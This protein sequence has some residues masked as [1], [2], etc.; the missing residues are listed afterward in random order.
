MTPFAPPPAQQPP[1]QYRHVD[2]A[3]PAELAGPKLV[4]ARLEM[5]VLSD[6]AYSA[7]LL[8]PEQLRLYC[9]RDG[10]SVAEFIRKH[11]TL[12]VTT[13]VN[14]GYFDVEPS[15]LLLPTGLVVSQSTV[16]WPSS[17][18]VARGGDGAR[19]RHAVKAARESAWTAVVYATRDGHAGILP[20][21]EFDQR[22]LSGG[23]YPQI[24][25]ALEAGPLLVCNG[26]PTPGQY[27]LL[28]SSNKQVHRSA[29]GV[30]ADGTIVLFVTKNTM[31]Y[32]QAAQALL[33]IGAV[34]A[35]AL[36]G[37][38]SSAFFAPLHPDANVTSPGSGVVGDKIS[39]ILYAAP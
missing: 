36:D 10:I 27:D 25:T 28:G 24:R 3:G 13:A 4:R 19:A 15:G 29:V 35:M 12:A 31:T 6:T 26:K 5:R 22:F 2:G 20:V 23:C 21:A 30:T 33:K 37:G 14:G 7:R 34:D 11:R 1:A 8:L 38:P 32:G 39:T 9:A 17:M 18:V 16:L